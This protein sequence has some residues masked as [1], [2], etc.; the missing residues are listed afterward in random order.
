MFDLRE[1]VADGLMRRRPN[2]MRNDR[3]GERIFRD[4]RS[5]ERV[6]IDRRGFRL[7]AIRY[8]GEAVHAV[9]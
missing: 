6:Q 1:I 2:E 4:R 9:W 8:P 7:G 3:E 5:A